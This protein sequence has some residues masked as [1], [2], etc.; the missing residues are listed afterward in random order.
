[1]N[2]ELSVF[3]VCN[4]H[5]QF[6]SIFGRKLQNPSYLIAF[7][8]PPRSSRRCAES[9][10]WGTSR[11]GIPGDVPGADAQQEAGWADS[12]GGPIR[13]FR[14]FRGNKGGGYVHRSHGTLSRPLVPG[15]EGGR[16][17]MPGSSA[18]KSANLPNGQP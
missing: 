9:Q 14:S 15:W 10:R 8:E 17:E 12:D 16:E 6:F 11:V 7:R 5:W 18:R 4:S 3:S 2:S 13:T 1:M